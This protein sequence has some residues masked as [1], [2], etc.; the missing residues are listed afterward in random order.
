MRNLD[1]MLGD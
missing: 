1:A